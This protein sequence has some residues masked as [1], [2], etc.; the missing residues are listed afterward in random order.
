MCSTLQDCGA[1]QTLAVPVY[2]G[3]AMAHATARALQT[4]ERDSNGTGLIKGFMG[5]ITLFH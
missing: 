5:E 1:T 4:N 2:E 3:V